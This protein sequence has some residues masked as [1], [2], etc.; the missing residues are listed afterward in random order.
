M[1]WDG[2]NSSVVR[3]GKRY[4]RSHTPRP[5]ELIKEKDLAGL[6]SSTILAV[7]P[8]K[9]EL[10]VMISSDAVVC[11]PISEEFKTGIWQPESIKAVT[12]WIFHKKCLRAGRFENSS[13]FCFSPRL[14]QQHSYACIRIMDAATLDSLGCKNASSQPPCVMR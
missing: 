1:H 8:A 10:N 9:H 14:L 13:L 11:T 6:T 7:L 12:G 5:G 4:R 3:S 2:T